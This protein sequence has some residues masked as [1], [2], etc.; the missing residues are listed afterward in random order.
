[1]KHIC[2]FAGNI[3]L[4]GGTERTLTLVANEMSQRGYI[5]TILNLWGGTRPFFALGSSIKSVNLF[6]ERISFAKN[7]LKAVHLL[8]SY[9]KANAVDVLVSVESTQSLY[10]LPACT[11]LGV[12][13]VNWEHFNS[14]VDLGF[15]PRRIARYLAAKFSDHIV[16][17]TER[18]N[19]LWQKT[20]GVRHKISTIPNAIPFSV[21]VDEGERKNAML[22]VGR[23]TFQKGFDLLLEAWRLVARHSA[24]CQLWIVGDGE[25]KQKLKA[26]VEE[27]QLGGSVI[28]F[29]PT[30]TISDYYSQAKWFCLSSRFEGFPM[31]LLEASS[32]GLPIVA[33]D[34]DTGPAEIITHRANGLLCPPE[35]TDALSAAIVEAFSM[36]DDAYKCMQS[37]AR[38]TAEK[39]TLPRIGDMWVNLF[40]ET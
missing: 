20:L 22:A 35:D 30:S 18:D 8:R 9:V 37:M 5:V 39:F 1:M 15:Y 13:Q 16:V 3:D 40:E 21:A 19:G 12:T 25:D 24:D 10:A 32:W 38:T 11:G 17:L 28:I 33:F 31:V 4:G 36:S 34:C 2:F 14:K 26:L 6:A 29:E 7:F 23:F 27:Y